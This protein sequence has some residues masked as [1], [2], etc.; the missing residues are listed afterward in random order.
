MEPSWTSRA[1]ALSVFSFTAWRRYRLRRLHISSSS[2][3]I[4]S[5]ALHKQQHASLRC[6]SF[7]ATASLSAASAIVLG[8][9][10]IFS[11]RLMAASA[12][13]SAFSVQLRLQLQRAPDGSFRFSFSFSVQRS[14]FSFQP[15]ASASALRQLPLQFQRSAFSFGFNLNERLTAA[16]ASVSAFS[17]SCS[18][19]LLRSAS[20]FSVQRSA[21]SVS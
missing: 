19:Q 12:S 1:A 20:A 3:F 21:F 9:C 10:I 18:A 7:Y 17:F 2:G 15:S 8:A 16:S 14:A 11:E 6:D 13:V 4:F 5:Y